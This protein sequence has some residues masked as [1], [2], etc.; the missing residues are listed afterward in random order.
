MVAVL[1]KFPETIKDYERNK[2]LLFEISEM[3]S[4]ELVKKNLTLFVE[5]YTKDFVDIKNVMLGDKKD[6][7]WNR[8][9]DTERKIRIGKLFTCKP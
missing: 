1:S 4:D 3:V 2:F 6:F 9:N 5:D 8:G 7:E